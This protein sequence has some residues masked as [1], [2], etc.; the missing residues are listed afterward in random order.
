MA[1]SCP[2]LQ[3]PLKAGGGQYKLKPKSIQKDD[4]KPETIPERIDGSS[5]A[6]SSIDAYLIDLDKGLT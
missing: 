5:S 4:A 2:L 6:L 1:R 3:V